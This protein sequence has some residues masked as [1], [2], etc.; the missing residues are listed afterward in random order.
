MDGAHNGSARVDN[1]THRPH[2]NGRC[3]GVQSWKG[4]KQLFAMS[5]AWHLKH[6][7]GGVLRWQGSE[8][9]G[10]STSVLIQTT[11][12]TIRFITCYITRYNLL[13]ALLSNVAQHLVLS[14]RWFPFGSPW[15]PLMSLDNRHV[16]NVTD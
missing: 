8:R 2:H 1:V 13:D 9:N 4:H 7:G 11:R 14:E 10:R 5:P 15:T 3:S 16:N 12:C 6:E